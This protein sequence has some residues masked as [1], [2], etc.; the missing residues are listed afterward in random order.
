MAR[1]SRLFEQLR[2]Y[3]LS[4]LFTTYAGEIEVTWGLD[5]SKWQGEGCFFNRHEI[6]EIPERA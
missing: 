2:F 4:P 5:S 3:L 6:L 1:E